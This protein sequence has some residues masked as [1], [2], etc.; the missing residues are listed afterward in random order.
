MTLDD[1]TNYCIYCGRKHV[2]GTPLGEYDEWCSN[3]LCNF[4]HD[5]VK[6]P[7]LW[8]LFII[9]PAIVLIP[10]IFGWGK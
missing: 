1:E 7:M 6:D 10:L 2:W 8:G 9:Y 4:K 5:Y 3:S